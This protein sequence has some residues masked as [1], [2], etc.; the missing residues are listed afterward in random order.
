[1]LVEC[2]AR[3]LVDWILDNVILLEEGSLA[4]VSQSP[5]VARRTLSISD[6]LYRVYTAFLYEQGSEYSCRPSTA[7]GFRLSDP[8]ASLVKLPCCHCIMPFGHLGFVA[9]SYC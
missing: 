8:F 1:M 3:D 7:I 6:A 4:I 2:K 9:V 5:V